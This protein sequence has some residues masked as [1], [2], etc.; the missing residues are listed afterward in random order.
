AGS[1]SP[2]RSSSLVVITGPQGLDP[3]RSPPA[4]SEP[5]LDARSPPVIDLS[6]RGGRNT[7]PGTDMTVNLATLITVDVPGAGYWLDQEG[8]IPSRR[9]RQHGARPAPLARSCRVGETSG[10]LTMPSA[11]EEDRERRHLGLGPHR[12]IAPR[13]ARRR[14]ADGGSATTRDLG[15]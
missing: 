9:S 7:G 12:R 4:G 5:A 6:S 1:V 15:R 10:V 8:S 14:P 3:P 11:P 2:S 13:C